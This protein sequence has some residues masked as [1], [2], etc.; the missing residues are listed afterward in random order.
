[1]GI[2]E[3]ACHRLH[4]H[5]PLWIKE[6]NELQMALCSGIA[7]VQEKT[8][9]NYTLCETLI[10]QLPAHMLIFQIAKWY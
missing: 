7:T 8:K 2:E 3:Q 10:V 6:I 1:M 5:I 4:V 9:L